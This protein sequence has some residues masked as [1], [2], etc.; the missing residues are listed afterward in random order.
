MFPLIY[1]F[2]FTWIQ[3]H[4]HTHTHV[5]FLCLFDKTSIRFHFIEKAHMIN[6]NN[7]FRS[8]TMHMDGAITSAFLNPINTKYTQTHT[9]TIY[10]ERKSINY[11]WGSIRFL[12]N[13][14]VCEYVRCIMSAFMKI[15]VSVPPKFHQPSLLF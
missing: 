15:A 8:S 14:F 1:C 3:Y 7:E 6:V 9:H 4:A 5:P 10:G 2:I 13:G 12:W 11:L